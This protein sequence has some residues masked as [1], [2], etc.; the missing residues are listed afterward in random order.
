MQRK[1]MLLC[2]NNICIY[3]LQKQVIV[4]NKHS[5]FFLWVSFFLLFISHSLGIWSKNK[6][7]IKVGT[8]FIP[9]QDGGK[10][11]RIVKPN[12]KKCAKKFNQTWYVLSTKYLYL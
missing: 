6:L 10:N 3:L 5:H 11:K 7:F 8:K 9:E 12:D 4:A 1:P 2:Q